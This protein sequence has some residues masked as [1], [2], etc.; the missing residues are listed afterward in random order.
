MSQP[1]E[2]THQTP[3][4]HGRLSQPRISRACD[5]CRT[6]KSRCNG[7]QP[8]TVCESRNDICT[9]NMRKNYD[10][11][12]AYTE[13]LER[14]R[15]QLISGLLRLHTQYLWRGEHLHR[16]LVRLNQPVPVHD[17]LVVLG[18]LENTSEE[19][20]D[21]GTIGEE[22]CGPSARQDEDHV[23]EDLEMSMRQDTEK[24]LDAVSL[25][26]DGDNLPSIIGSLRPGTSNKPN[27]ILLPQDPGQSTLTT[28]PS[29]PFNINSQNIV[30][31]PVDPLD[32][33]YSYHS[34]KDYFAEGIPTP[35][36]LAP[37]DTNIY[38]YSI[39][40]TALERLNRE[41]KEW[42]YYSWGAVAK[43]TVQNQAQ[44]KPEGP[45]DSTGQEMRDQTDEDEQMHD[46]SGYITIPL[47]LN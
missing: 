16:K 30:Q 11:S 17:L 25:E 1:D 19:R 2:P 27:H 23:E 20:F 4:S 9:Y 33:S 39:V 45:S 41:S 5:G 3:T 13:L 28:H 18:V 8:C 36:P 12:Q 32:S 6:R 21:V 14:Q 15:R 37:S 47:V 10:R 7:H 40:D 44:S 34:T 22:E 35:A 29:A 43:T 46:S 24:P 42:T 38:G 31:P 26:Q